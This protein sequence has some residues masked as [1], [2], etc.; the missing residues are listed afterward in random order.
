MWYAKGRVDAGA[1]HDPKRNANASSSRPLPGGQSQQTL[2]ANALKGKSRS[3]GRRHTFNGTATFFGDEFN[4]A[5]SNFII[6]ASGRIGMR[7]LHG[8]CSAVVIGDLFNT[9]YSIFAIGYG[10]A[11][12][13][14]SLITYFVCLHILSVFADQ[15]QV[16]VI[17]VR[18]NMDTRS[19]CKVS[20][21][22]SV[23]INTLKS[24]PKLLL[25]S[26]N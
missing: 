18:L 4:T 3:P 15:K 26:F 13:P 10:K 7:A 12:Q 14:S 23:K 20:K 11:E 6:G 25:T 8:D 22:R 21:D 17:E 19:A 1:A 16:P 24:E 2:L 5:P 9:G